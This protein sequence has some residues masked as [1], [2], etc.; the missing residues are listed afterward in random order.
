MEDVRESDL[1]PLAMEDSVRHSLADARFMGIR[2]HHVVRT[3]G[4]ILGFAQLLRRWRHNSFYVV[5]YC[6]GLKELQTGG[7]GKYRHELRLRIAKR[8]AVRTLDISDISGTDRDAI[9]EKKKKSIPAIK[10]HHELVITLADC[11]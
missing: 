1:D 7:D 6:A 3:A 5:S 2:D 10:R 8:V 11:K 4:E 9:S